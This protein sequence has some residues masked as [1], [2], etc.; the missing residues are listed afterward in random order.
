MTDNTQNLNGLPTDN[1]PSTQLKYDI[2]ASK[3]M[4]GIESH[5]RRNAPAPSPMGAFGLVGAVLQGVVALVVIGR[6]FGVVGLEKVIKQQ[7]QPC[8]CLCFLYLNLN[9]VNF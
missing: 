6:G 5:Q 8:G 1:S 3:F 9:P 7:R 4:A 2:V